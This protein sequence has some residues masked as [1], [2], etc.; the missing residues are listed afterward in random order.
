MG[1]HWALKQN[2]TTKDNHEYERRFDSRVSV[3][4]HNN[5]RF[6]LDVFKPELG[7]LKGVKVKLDI[8]RS[9]PPKFYKPRPLPFALKKK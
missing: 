2:I 4:S 7:E 6:H 8:D 5:L 9:V 3:V 1:V